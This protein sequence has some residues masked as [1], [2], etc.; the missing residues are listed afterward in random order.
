MINCTLCFIFSKSLPL[1]PA[2]DF[3]NFDPYFEHHLTLA[4]LH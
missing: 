1:K 2:Q 3:Y 4:K